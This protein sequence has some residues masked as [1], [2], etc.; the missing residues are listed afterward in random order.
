MFSKDINKITN[1]DIFLKGIW[2]FLETSDVNFFSIADDINNNK[3][4]DIINPLFS[5]LDDLLLYVSAIIKYLNV[6][7][8]WL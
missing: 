3:K 8:I 5:P 1:N 7:S 2:K 6:K 4:D